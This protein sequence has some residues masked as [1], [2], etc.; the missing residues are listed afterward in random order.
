MPTNFFRALKPKKIDFYIL[1]ELIGPFTGGVLF[2]IFVF[3]MFQA[4]RLAEFFIIH[5]VSGLLLAKLTSLMI[6]SFLPTVLPVAFLLSI[7][8]GFGRLSADSELV[9]MKACGISVWRLTVTPFI[10]S[11]F[12]SI[13]SLAL[14][15][16]WVP[17]GD[18]LFKTTLMKVSNTKVASSIKEGAFN[19]DF[20]D[21]L[22]F[23]DKYDSKTNRLK[24]VFLFDEREPKNPLTVI[25]EE[26]ELLSVKSSNSF[27]TAALLKL[28]RGNIH[29]NDLEA[30]TYQKIDF[31]EYR[32]FLKIDE[33]SDSTTIKPKMITTDQLLK[34][35][36]TSPKSSSNYRE[37]L[38][39]L[40]RRIA[41]GISPLFFVF[42]GIGYGT[43]RTR[44]VRTSATLVAFGVIVIFWTLQAFGTMAAHDGYLHPA[45]ALLLPDIALMIIAFI[46]FKTALW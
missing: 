38:S 12:V 4:L 30:K 17:W 11:I 42:L 27:G 18:R 32:L 40:T 34:S 1:S 15:L 22:I 26:G 46:G 7:L 35:I 13:F 9:A 37:H 14:N 33:G 43:V 24:H 25:A 41:V 28:H 10:F 29:R 20:F 31:G 36:R 45:L 5:G 16:E 19:S 21:L 23:A 44:A 8:V 39:E 2:F 3:L 6:L